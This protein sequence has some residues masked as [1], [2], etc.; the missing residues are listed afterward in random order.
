MRDLQTGGLSQLSGW[1]QA[2]LGSGR[3]PPKR[4][5]G[6]RQQQA[7][8]MAWGSLTEDWSQIHDDQPITMGQCTVTEN[9][10]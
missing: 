5:C 1:W 10:L 6:D 8:G 4:P 3:Q 7:V 2:T 9:I